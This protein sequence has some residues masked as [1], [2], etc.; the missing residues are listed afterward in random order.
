MKYRQ[1]VVEASVCWRFT[2]SR[3]RTRPQICPDDLVWNGEQFCFPRPAAA[4][5]ASGDAAS[6]GFDAVV[7][8]KA[9]AAT[10]GKGTPTGALPAVCDESTEFKHKH[11]HWC[12]APC[13]AGFLAADARCR[14]SCVG[15]FQAEGGSVMCGKSP[16]AIAQAVMQM[17]VETLKTLATVGEQLDEMRARGIAAEPLAGTIQALINLGVPF[18]YDRCPAPEA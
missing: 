6:E 15:E 11:G 2:A 4:L 12:Y 5:I 16:V 13:P 8:R 18:A 1:H 3:E 17:V 14:V 10:S 9:D 7:A